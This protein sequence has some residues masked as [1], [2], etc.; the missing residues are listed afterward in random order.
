MNRN[1]HAI[2]SHLAL[3]HSCGL[4]RSADLRKMP[5]DCGV[6]V[7]GDRIY[8]GSPV[9]FISFVGAFTCSPSRLLFAVLFGVWYTSAFWFFR[10]VGAGI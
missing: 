5:F 3:C 2:T 6:H 10:S 7:V 9:N 8:L 4:R 1:A